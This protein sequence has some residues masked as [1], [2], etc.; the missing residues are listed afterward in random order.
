MAKF[1]LAPVGEHLH[2]GWQLQMLTID[3]LPWHVAVFVAIASAELP[4]TGLRVWEG[5]GA[6]HWVVPPA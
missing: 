3:F 2:P 6:L 1:D 5:Q 4:L